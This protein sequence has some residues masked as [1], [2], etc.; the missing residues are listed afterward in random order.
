MMASLL[1]HTTH[2]LYLPLF[3]FIDLITTGKFVFLVNCL[4]MILTAVMFVLTENTEVSQ[5][6]GRKLHRQDISSRLDSEKLT[7]ATTIPAIMVEASAN[8]PSPPDPSAESVTLSYCNVQIIDTL[9]CDLENT[10]YAN[11]CPP[12]LQQ[13]EKRWLFSSALD[14]GGATY[15]VSTATLSAIPYSSLKNDKGT[16]CDYCYC[17]A[18]CVLELIWCPIVSAQASG[19]ELQ[20]HPRKL[21]LTSKHFFL[22]RSYLLLLPSTSGIDIRAKEKRLILD[23]M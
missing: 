16:G 21:T 15:Q 19:R 13:L 12:S 18:S 23:T 1:W 8:T 10:I 20:I 11:L 3:E 14:A 7:C 6:R 9:P 17:K 5:P 22:N 4:L 2:T